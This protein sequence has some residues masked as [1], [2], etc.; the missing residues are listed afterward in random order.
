MFILIQ[1]GLWLLQNIAKYRHVNPLPLSK[2]DKFVAPFEERTTFA[3]L[4]FEAW[5]LVRLFIIWFVCDDNAG[6]KRRFSSEFVAKKTTAAGAG[7]LNNSV[8]FRLGAARTESWP[9]MVLNPRSSARPRP[10][11]RCDLRAVFYP[12]SSVVFI[13]WL[14]LCVSIVLNLTTWYFLD[15]LVFFGILF[16]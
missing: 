4:F 6:W 7:Q 9:C 8:L 11:Y 10:S 13:E 5:V 12:P 2:S 14:P 3:D 1:W 16:K 15:Y